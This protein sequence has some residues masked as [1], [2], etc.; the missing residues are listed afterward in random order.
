M[1]QYVKR[2]ISQDS[3]RNGSGDGSPFV[4]TV[5]EPADERGRF[6]AMSFGSTFDEFRQHTGVVKI[7]LLPNVEFARGNSWRGADH[8]GAEIAKAWQ[9][10]C[11]G[12]G[13]FEDYRYDPFDD[14]WDPE[15]AENA[16]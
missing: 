1:R 3:H 7:S 9:E 6:V 2:I 5:F 11:K 12:G 4:V 10:K 14:S 15:S 16:S 8:Y 13:R